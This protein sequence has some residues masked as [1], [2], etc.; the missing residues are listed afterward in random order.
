VIVT[1]NVEGSPQD[2]SAP[3]LL[4]FKVTN[5]GTESRSVLVQGT[6]LDG[7]DADI[8]LVER[9]GVPVPY[10]GKLVKRAQLT[11]ED[12]SEI[13]PGSSLEATFD[14]GEAYD[15]SQE[16][17]YTFRYRAVALGVLPPK[18]FTLRMA[19]R[20]AELQRLE[21][22][23]VEVTL[24][25]KGETPSERLAATK[26]GGGKPSG[27]ST[28]TATQQAILATAASNATMISTKAFA[29]LS[30]STDDPD[31]LYKTWFDASGEKRFWS[32]V[33]DHFEAI[34]QAFSA[35]VATFDCSCKKRYYAYVYPTQPYTIYL[36]SIFWSA[37]DLGQ[38]SK[39]GTLVHEMS[40][41]DV[42]AGTEDWVYGATNAMSLAAT[43]VT[44]STTNA[45]NHEYFAEHQ[46]Y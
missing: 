4:R 11:E 41:F 29:Y 30:T 42:V 26:P 40:H 24:K 15:L 39:A 13:P 10:E 14:P 19:R 1:L 28:C 27:G 18:A 3:L 45:D 43:D 25:G 31:G 23:P 38:D 5:T 22:E 36:C 44:K 33:T 9:D 46:K 12:F 16:G 20:E 21:S 17:T 37:P 8:L 34:S 32:T 6:P 7:L 2:R 35:N